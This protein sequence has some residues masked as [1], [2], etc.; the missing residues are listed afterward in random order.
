MKNLYWFGTTN[1]LFKIFNNY[2]VKCFGNE[3]DSHSKKK[4]T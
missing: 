3:E 1:L 4:I 2:V